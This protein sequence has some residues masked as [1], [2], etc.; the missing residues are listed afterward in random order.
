MSILSTTRPFRFKHFFRDLFTKWFDFVRK[1]CSI[2]KVKFY[3]NPIG[4]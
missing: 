4:R 2:N 1:W 3:F